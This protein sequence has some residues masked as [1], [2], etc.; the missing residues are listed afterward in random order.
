MRSWKFIVQ[1]AAPLDDHKFLTARSVQILQLIIEEFVKSARFRQ[2]FRRKGHRLRSRNT[3]CLC[4]FPDGWRTIALVGKPE[5]VPHFALL[6]KVF[7]PMLMT[8]CLNQG[9]V[10]CRIVIGG[11]VQGVGFRRRIREFAE[12]HAISGWV[13]SH[14]ESIEIHA[15]GDPDCLSRFLSELKTSPPPMGSI[16][17]FQ[18]CDETA[19]GASSFEIRATEQ[20]TDRTT[21]YPVDLA[22]C[23]DCR[24][25]L[26]DPQN[27]R[28][29]YAF[30]SCTKCGPRYSVM[31]S[32]PYERSATSMADWKICNTCRKE[33]KSFDDARHQDQLIAC[34]D[35]G[36]QYSLHDS[37]QQIVTDEGDEAIASAASRLKQGQIVAIKS[38]G[39]YQLACDARNIQA[40]MNLRNRKLRKEK[41]FALM[42]RTIEEARQLADLTAAHEHELQNSAH[43]IV[44]APFKK[45]FAEVPAGSA[46][47]G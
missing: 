22:L 29:R 6:L 12:H 17:R 42:V 26:S 39:G 45:G 19:V 18:V 38:I 35:C 9:I 7:V 47:W 24:H 41:P 1:S 40:V 44:L 15:E 10:A 14:T 4:E 43:P 11:V 31:R 23:D 5:T 32:L 27:R 30:T 34:H 21:P 33:Q 46:V 37:R 13:R 28:H 2:T 3:S 25:D 20:A 36:P 16:D 8:S